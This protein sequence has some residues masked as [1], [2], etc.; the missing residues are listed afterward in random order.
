MAR[1]RQPTSG[2]LP[3]KRLRHDPL[4][5]AKI[6]ALWHRERVRDEY[7]AS[8]YPSH[9]ARK[10]ANQEALEVARSRGWKGDLNDLKSQL[11]QLVAN[12]IPELRRRGRPGIRYWEEVVHEDL[13]RMLESETENFKVELAG[14]LRNEALVRGRFSGHL[15]LYKLAFI[16]GYVPS[17]DHLE[18]RNAF[19]A[20]LLKVGHDLDLC[21]TKLFKIILRFSREFTLRPF[22]TRL[23]FSMPRAERARRPAGPRPPEGKRSRP[24]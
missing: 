11:G 2:A 22:E 23:G 14:Y 6:T 10:K 20:T 15:G 5:W 16:L 4:F 8:G 13:L 3:L 12:E 17:M 19:L 9:E 18:K 21:D 24:E 7:V 1:G